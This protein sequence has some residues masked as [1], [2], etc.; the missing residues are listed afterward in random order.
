LL[1]LNPLAKNSGGWLINASRQMKPIKILLLIAAAWCGLNSVVA[2]T[3]TM[4]SAPFGE[5]SSIASSADGSKLVAVGPENAGVCISTNSGTTWTLNSA[6]LNNQPWF[7]SIASSADGTKLAVV[8]IMGPIYTSTNSGATWISNSLPT[9]V[10]TSIAS[11]ADGSKLVA[12]AWSNLIYT[13]TDSGATWTSNSTVTDNQ[14]FHSAT[15][16][17]D[18]TKLAIAAYGGMIY[19]STNSGSTWTTVTSVP[20]TNWEAIAS[21]A[22]GTK[23]A[24]IVQS[25]L[26]YTSPDT[27]ATWMSNNLPASQWTSIASSADGNKLAAVANGPIYLSTN[28]GTTW[29]LDAGNNYKWG[30]VAS[31]AD[32]SKLVGLIGT[33]VEN[34]QVTVSWD[35]IYSLQTT[36]APQLNL[37]PTNGN[38]KLSWIVPSTNFVM[39]QSSDLGSWTDMTNK[40]TLNLTNLHNEVILPPPGCNVFYRLKTP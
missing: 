34:D 23:L 3:W 31:S 25:G 29:T 19:T 12:V 40:P 5:W 11:S 37:T 30:F 26:V 36:P 4:T 13:S 27:G 33:G 32:G 17:A 20:S 39:Q 8:T 28:S 15:S 2:Q 1:P 22:D 9:A 38:L 6:V 10:W 7:P 14:A 35:G 24:A 16:S 21:S 18:G